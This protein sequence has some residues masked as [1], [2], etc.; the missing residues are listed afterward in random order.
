[1]S[2]TEAIER[3]EKFY[4]AVDGAYRCV[5]CRLTPDECTCRADHP[6]RVILNACVL[7][8]AFGSVE[9]GGRA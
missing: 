5:A 7:H 1:M 4:D 2:R 3:G 6:M 9:T 8:G